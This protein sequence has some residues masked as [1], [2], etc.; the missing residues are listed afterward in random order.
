MR[1]IIS[2]P[3][4]HGARSKNWLMRSMA[5]S[6][7]G[8]TASHSGSLAN[9]LCADYHLLSA[10]NKGIMSESTTQRMTFHLDQEHRGVRYAVILI[11]FLSFVVAFAVIN[12]VLNAVAPQLNTTVILSCLGAIPVCLGFSALGEWYLKRHWHSGRML[13]VDSERITA[14]LD[15]DGELHMARDKH[16]NTLWWE[17]PLSGYARGGRERRIPAKWSC[18]AGQLQQDGMRV[19]VFCYATPQRLT[20]WREQYEFEKLKPEDVYN[21]SFSARFGSPDRP[22]LPA[23]VIAGKQ[24]RHWLAE[25][26][27]WR[28]GVEMTQDDFE[29]FLEM[30]RMARE[31]RSGAA[32]RAEVA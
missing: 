19:V 14:H 2:G 30:M 9:R 15:D 18:V 20:A 17:V 28:D 3:E 31:Q 7:A 32:Q 6:S 12:A 21:T 24:G 25:R 4:Q 29:Q 23:E 10:L 5:G 8:K 16:M 26:N 22:E 1:S 11:L 27:R 13:I